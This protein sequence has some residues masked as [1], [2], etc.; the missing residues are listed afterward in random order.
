MTLTFTPALNPAGGLPHEVADRVNQILKGKI[1]SRNRVTLSV[2]DF[3]VLDDLNIGLDSV[4]LFSPMSASAAATA[5][6]G[7]PWV[8][9]TQN[10]QAILQ[11]AT[12]ASDRLFGYLVIG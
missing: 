1:N 10:G 2:G 6:N 7:M 9:I 11:H 3:T 12:G 5:A 4:I 8:Q